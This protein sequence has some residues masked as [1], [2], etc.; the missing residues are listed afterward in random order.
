MP[1]RFVFR[2]A[3]ARLVPRGTEAAAMVTR[4]RQLDPVSER[5][6]PG[7]STPP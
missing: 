6:W 5:P 2:P 3:V 1:P 4:A 7:R